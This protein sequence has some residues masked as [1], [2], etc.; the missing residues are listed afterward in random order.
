MN[1]TLKNVTYDLH[2]RGNNIT[3][4]ER[5]MASKGNKISDIESKGTYEETRKAILEAGLEKI[6]EALEGSSFKTEEEKDA[7]EKKLNEKIKLGSKLSQSEMNYIQRTN[8]AMYVHIKR[9]QMQR[10][11]L[12]KQLK[13]C[14]S[15][16][17]VE[18]AY[19]QAISMIDRKDPDK[20]L[21]VSAYNN[22]TNEFKKTS[23]YKSLPLDIKDKKDEKTVAKKKVTVD[24]SV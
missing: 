13:R 24:L 8:P 10:E 16:K 3:S 20:H 12:E 1:V 4:N 11:L 17:E 6:K 7:Y 22:V 23:E 21:L 15:K 5:N 19:T 14:R 18:E 2:N 9:V